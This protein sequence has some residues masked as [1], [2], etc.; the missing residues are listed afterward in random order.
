MKKSKMDVVLNL[1]MT[2]KFTTNLVF[3]LW[4]IRKS[5]M[6]II[7][8]LRLTVRTTTNSLYKIKVD[9]DVSK[10][11]MLVIVKIVI[12]PIHLHEQFY[13]VSLT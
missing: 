3:K 10:T 9:E 2:R 1:R 7:L 5:T 11:K 6:D 4:L 12:H 8:E 13:L